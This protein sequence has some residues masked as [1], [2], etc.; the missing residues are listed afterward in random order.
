MITLTTIIFLLILS[1]IYSMAVYFLIR[2]ECVYRFRNKVLD[3]YNRE[4]YLKM[5]SYDEMVF[6]YF[7]EWNFNK[8][9][10]MGDK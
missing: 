8:F 4:T 10:S 1:F 7:Y 9:I 3:E 5:P 6:K 2:N